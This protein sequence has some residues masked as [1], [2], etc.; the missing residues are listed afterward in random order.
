LDV[1]AIVPNVV[2]GAALLVE[3]PP[4]RLDSIA[5]NQDHWTIIQEQRFLSGINAGFPTL[6]IG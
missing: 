4:E 5:V 3:Q 2:N 1:V 6:K